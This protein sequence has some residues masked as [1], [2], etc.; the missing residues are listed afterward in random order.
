MP[1]SPCLARLR[2][3]YEAIEARQLGKTVSSAGA[4]GRSVSYASSN[5]DD[6]IRFYR[7]LAAQCPDF[8]ASDLPRLNDPAASTVERGCLRPRVI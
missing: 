6:L 4:K 3:I 2:S 8:A 7:Q 5:L 1:D